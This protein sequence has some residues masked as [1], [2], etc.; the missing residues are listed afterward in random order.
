MPKKSYQQIRAFVKGTIAEHVP[1]VPVSALNNVNID[2]LIQTIQ[3]RFPTPVRDLKKP[4]VMFVARSF[5]INKPGISF[6]KIEGGVVGGALKHG[7]LRVG[8]KVEILPGKKVER[9]GRVTWVPIV[10]T[11]VGIRTGDVDLREALPGAS[12]AVRTMLDPGLTKS[13]SLTGNMV[14]LQGQLPPVHYE[15]KL[16]PHLLERVVGSEKELQVQPIKKGENL[17]LNVNSAMTVGIVTELSKRF[18][19]GEVKASGVR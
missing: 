18:F 4:P 12:I 5:D 3:D 17:M 13:D 6:Q 10:T 2:L 9:E 19:H 8:E 16:V 7:V 14:G 1:I 11:V 15:L